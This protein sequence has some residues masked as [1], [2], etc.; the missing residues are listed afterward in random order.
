ME[1]TQDNDYILID[2]T[3]QSGHTHCTTQSGHTHCTTQSGHTPLETCV[4]SLY[5]TDREFTML[6][7]IKDYLLPIWDSYDKN[8]LKVWKQFCRDFP[9]MDFVFDGETITDPH[10]FFKKIAKC[11]FKENIIFDNVMTNLLMIML[12][13]QSS[14]G[15]PYELL[16]EIYGDEDNDQ[17]VIYRHDRN[18]VKF[19]TITSGVQYTLNTTFHISNTVSQ[20]TLYRINVS[21]SLN[22]QTNQKQL[23][24][25]M[26][27]IFWKLTN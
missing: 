10:H 20:Q 15:F 27:I 5:D 22:I 7:D 6:F 18:T 21:L 13:N 16:T 25:Q 2:C 17:Y 26:G 9:R 4:K 23:G 8:P 11:R 24:K 19:T 12:C 14:F 3:T 1:I